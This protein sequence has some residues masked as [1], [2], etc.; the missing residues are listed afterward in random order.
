M[1]RT[2]SGAT[3]PGPSGPWTN[4]NEDV[5]H[6]FQVQVSPSDPFMSHG[7]HSLRE[8]LLLCRDVVGVF[9][10]PN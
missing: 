7:K 10:S 1:D 4:D 9:Y 2:L 5:L 8:A 3:T 6:I